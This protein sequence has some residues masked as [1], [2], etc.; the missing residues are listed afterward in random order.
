MEDDYVR[1]DERDA[2]ER[3][4][5]LHHY[6][7]SLRF[8]DRSG[9]EN[10]DWTVFLEND[11]S[12][13]L[14][15]IAHAPVHDFKNYL[16]QLERLDHILDEDE[17]L[18][19]HLDI[20]GHL[21]DWAKTVGKWH[22]HIRELGVTEMINELHNAISDT[23]APAADQVQG[24][25][26]TIR[27]EEAEHS[28]LRKTLDEDPVWE[29]QAGSLNTL[30]L[31][32]DDESMRGAN[33]SDKLRQ[34]I[35]IFQRTIQ[36]LVTRARE[37]YDGTLQRDDHQPHTAMMLAFLELFEGSRAMINSIGR[38]HL[39]FYYRDVLRL[40]HQQGNPDTV[41]VCFE[42]VKEAKRALVLEGTQLAAGKLSNGEESL[43][44]TDRTRIITQAKI[45]EFRTLFLEVDNPAE[46]HQHPVITSFHAAPVANSANGVG[47]P[48]LVPERGWP[49]FGE[50]QGN[51]APEDRTMQF[52]D[53]G[54]VLSQR[55]FFLAQGTRT[56]SIRF[57]FESF[58]LDP[59]IGLDMRTLIK[60]LAEQD[61]ISRG[62][63]IYRV[64]H[65][66]FLVSVT[67][68]KG[69]YDIDK[70]SVLVNAPTEAE[71]GWMQLAFTLSPDE[72]AL[73]LPKPGT[74]T[75]VESLQWPALRVKLN[76][77]NPWYVYSYINGLLLNE[78]SCKI[79]VKGIKQFSFYNQN[80]VLASD[81]PFQ[82]FGPLPHRGDYLLVGNSE[83]FC[84][85]LTALDLKVQW[86]GLPK[87]PG[88]FETYYE[89][90]DLD[91]ENE[92]FKV[93]M[94]VLTGGQWK[95][96]EA[97]DQQEFNLFET[98]PIDTP[99]GPSVAL[100][101]E[102]ALHGIDTDRMSFSPT[103]VPREP[104]VFGPYTSTGYFKLE[105]T[106][107][108]YGF[109][110][111][112]YRDALARVTI[113]NARKKRN[114]PLPN[115]PFVP[116]IREVE[117]NY[118]S[119]SRLD[120]SPDFGVGDLAGFQAELYH[121]NPFGN[122]LVRSED[123]NKSRRLVPYFEEGG[124]LLLGL[125]DIEHT[126]KLSMLFE[127]CT[128]NEKG[129]PD[130]LPVLQWEYL[131]NDQW[132]RFDPE[133][134]DADTT[135]GFLTS[136]IIDLLLPK[137]LTLGN[138]ILPEDKYWIRINMEKV[139]GHVP[140]LI[141]VRTQAVTATWLPDHGG[142]DRLNHSIAPFTIKGLA[143]KMPLIKSVVQPLSSF[144][145]RGPEDGKGFYT[146]V[147]ERLR[148]KNRCQTTWDTQRLVL[149]AFPHLIAVK[150]VRQDDDST[151]TPGRVMIAVVSNTNWETNSLPRANVDTL[152]RIKS[153][154]QKMSSPFAKV[155]VKNVIYE[156]LLVNCKVLFTDPTK[157]GYYTNRLNWDVLRYISPWENEFGLQ[158]AIGSEVETNSILSYIE[159][160]S[161][162]TY[163]TGFSVECI[164][165]LRGRHQLAD[166][167]LEQGAN[168]TIKPRTPRSLFVSTVKH[169]IESMNESD[170]E[171]G[172]VTGIGRMQIGL[173]FIIV[174][175]PKKPD[176]VTEAHDHDAGEDG[177][178][179]TDYNLIVVK[180]E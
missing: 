167:A 47:K 136:G 46:A 7:K 120:F 179:G 44:A 105:L 3:L 5:Y 29:L 67:T 82:P 113:T 141:H 107:P 78:I 122:T 132:V 12:I 133:A 52:A 97:D 174:P 100:N 77:N 53:V 57:Y 143:N 9:V 111:E 98:H 124:Y 86:Q 61:G 21:S 93:S 151:P 76:P 19:G 64:F 69:W 34:L 155:S 40:K 35:K 173:D 38:R 156:E 1:I 74:I 149:Q 73:E 32:L 17:V 161:Y 85:R 92:S 110:D 55:D 165:H 166:T 51:H 75:E 79:S 112:A 11:P 129:M 84:K 128:D 96:Y 8:F 14:A 164:S 62:A 171:P 91:T 30:V 127:F 121:I 99:E 160:L 41:Y 81:K 43:F 138:N 130:R 22:D 18:H 26:D 13:Y 68:E 27:Q 60:Q 103:T 65:E 48:L 80:G 6:A 90:Y 39:E 36:Y 20:A 24:L 125:E 109:A 56:V 94:S 139:D 177:Q 71:D 170:Y 172:K 145:N 153:Y 117:M 63:A 37:L 50:S 148:H 119:M 115:P 118:E 33:N 123:V 154:V 66:A 176:E 140:N 59:E 15:I 134:V 95:P 152:M 126:E 23:L 162:V 16:D 104:N 168:T 169:R 114:D 88:G 175:E 2:T 45:T 108:E 142:A 4:S 137:D 42:P 10:E 146:R 72:P 25:F 147:S 131:R 31:G 83:V 101:N 159:N 158:L 89:A 157:S 102:T 163:V 150:V 180:P 106:E 87:N 28:D 178:Y 116:V 70:Y 144:G 49:T 58:I 54:F 135:Y